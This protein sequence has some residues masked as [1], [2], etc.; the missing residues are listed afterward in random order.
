M[1]GPTIRTAGS[2][3]LGRSEPGAAVRQGRGSPNARHAETLSLGHIHTLLTATPRPVL[4]FHEAS[5]FQ[6]RLPEALNAHNWRNRVFN[7]ATHDV[8]LGGTGLTSHKLRHTAASA[9]VV[10]GADV[11]V[12]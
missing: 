2:A 11:N 9:A 4:D 6:P 10:A 5:V 3:A 1:A 7:L 8:G 12:V